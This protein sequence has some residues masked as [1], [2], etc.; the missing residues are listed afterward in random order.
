LNRNGEVILDTWLLS[1]RT[2][3]R[4]ASNPFRYAMNDDRFVNFEEG[5]D[6]RNASSFVQCRYP[7]SK[8]YAQINILYQC[9]SPPLP[10]LLF[11]NYKCLS[12]CCKI[13]LLLS[14]R[15]HKWIFLQINAAA[16][17]VRTINSSGRGRL[18]GSLTRHRSMRTSSP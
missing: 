16:R 9:N 14:R 4:S 6:I 10:S 18:S 3:L 1:L 17:K 7:Y 11:L 15:H 5:K 2:S 8:L 13:Y 12:P